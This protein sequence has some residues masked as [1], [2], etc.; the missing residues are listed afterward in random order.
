MQWDDRTD[1]E[2]LIDRLM[3]RLD[4][5]AELINKVKLSQKEM[6][7]RLDLIENKLSKDKK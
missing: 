3:V 7:I 5:L 2:K 1:A 4:N 6:T